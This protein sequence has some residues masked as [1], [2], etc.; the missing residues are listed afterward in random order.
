[1]LPVDGYR[2]AE[3]I[4]MSLILCTQTQNRNN[5]GFVSHIFSYVAR[6]NHIFSANSFRRLV[7]AIC[8]QLGK[9]DFFAYIYVSG[10]CHY[11]K[12]V[13]LTARLLRS[14]PITS[15]GQRVTV[16]ASADETK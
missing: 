5:Y 11:F 15:K 6:R 12:S 13:K 2:T 16:S 3:L 4:K 14:V 10:G 9:S 7:L 8:I 1:M